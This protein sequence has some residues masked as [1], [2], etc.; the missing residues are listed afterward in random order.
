MTSTDYIGI[1]VLIS[2]FFTGM[3]SV[4]NSWKLTQV[5]NSVNGNTA[6]QN[7]LISTLHATIDDKT[8]QISDARQVAA[9]SEA[10]KP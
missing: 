4:I 10:K 3:V 9:V 7:A 1:G 2:T 5:H 8:K 6:A